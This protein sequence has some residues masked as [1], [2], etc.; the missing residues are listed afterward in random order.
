M[1]TTSQQ[2]C[3]KADED[4]K[5]SIWEYSS[6]PTFG[7]PKIPNRKIPVDHQ[8][9]PYYQL[10]ARRPC[11]DTLRKTYAL[12]A[13]YPINYSE[14]M[15]EAT[16]KANFLDFCSLAQK[17]QYIHDDF[18][19]WAREMALETQVLCGRNNLDDQSFFKW[20]ENHDQCEIE[21]KLARNKTVLHNL[22]LV[23]IQKTQELMARGYGEHKNQVEAEEKRKLFKCAF[24]AQLDLAGHV[25]QFAKVEDQ[26]RF[27]K[28]IE[29][30]IESN[31][32]R[33]RQEAGNPTTPT[34]KSGE[35]ESLKAHT[36]EEI[37]QELIEKVRM[38]ATKCSKLISTSTRDPIAPSVSATATSSLDL[39]AIPPFIRSFAS[40]QTSLSTSA[41]QPKTSAAPPSP[42]RSLSASP[43]TER[44]LRDSA[45]SGPA[46]P[47]SL[48]T[49]CTT[50]PSTRQVSPPKASSVIATP[51]KSPG[52]PI[53]SASAIS[54][55]GPVFGS[56]LKIRS[57]LPPC[58]KA[59][60][61]PP[62]AISSTRYTM[63]RHRPTPPEW[64]YPLSLCTLIISNMPYTP[65]DDGLINMWPTEA[66]LRLPHN[67]VLHTLATAM[68]VHPSLLLYEC[69]FP[70]PEARPRNADPKEIEYLIFGLRAW[71]ASIYKKPTTREEAFAR[72]HEREQVEEPLR[73]AFERAEKAEIKAMARMVWSLVRGMASG[74]SLSLEAGE[75]VR[76]WLGWERGELGFWN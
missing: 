64:V 20:V 39:P 34:R 69:P 68:N 30:Q 74:V 32:S 16:K 2:L 21:F 1:S 17:I 51:S 57:R 47:H 8:A 72:L 22:D 3:F 40:T 10:C 63:P 29:H 41:I 53:S 45:S 31:N 49:P 15:E 44:T 58:L 27:S 42:S 12:A 62:Q 66:V 6:E 5:K 56:P 55:Q 23:N 35:S 50:P 7:R 65:I 67:S 73:E 59:S 9:A 52:D 14:N 11:S 28:T 38:A 48:S 46:S 26:K 24:E 13:M 37:Q 25:E 54:G 36:K 70:S 18:D 75:K 71:W 76:E 43:S 61:A 4:S 33:R 60:A 19:E